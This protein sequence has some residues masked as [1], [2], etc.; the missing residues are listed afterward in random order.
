MQTR[1]WSSWHG[2]G[3]VAHSS[4]QL[5]IQRA[6]GIQCGCLGQCGAAWRHYSNILQAF[7]V[8]LIHAL[9]ARKMHACSAVSDSQTPRSSKVLQPVQAVCWHTKDAYRCQQLWSPQQLAA[10]LTSQRRCSCSA[11]CSM[12]NAICA[13]LCILCQQAAASALSCSCLLTLWRHALQAL[14]LLR[15][16]GARHSRAGDLQLLVQCPGVD[17]PSLC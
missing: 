17:Q 7:P 13:R 12:Y 3:P 2:A 5:D 1:A 4:Q 15:C 14:Q 10:S 9:A 8:Q 16:T 11:N 6:C